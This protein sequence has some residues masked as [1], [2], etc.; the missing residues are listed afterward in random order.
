MSLSRIAKEGWIEGERIEGK[1]SLDFVTIETKK[2]HV[3]REFKSFK[4]RYCVALVE[5]GVSNLTEHEFEDCKNLILSAPKM[6][7]M[8]QWL[9]RN[10][11][12][13]EKAEKIRAVLRMARGKK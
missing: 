8:L 5:K 12:D 7:S 6:R 1:Q 10:E 2:E 3:C 11:T 13:K 4:G 9:Y